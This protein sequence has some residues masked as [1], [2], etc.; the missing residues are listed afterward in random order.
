MDRRLCIL[1]IVLVF[2]TGLFCVT[3]IGQGPPDLTLLTRYPNP[4]AGTTCGV[5]GNPN[6]NAAKQASNRLKNRFKIPSLAQSISLTE[7]KRMP[8]EE[9]GE[10]PS[11]ESQSELD[12][13]SVIG[14]VVAVSL[15]GRSESCNCKASENWQRDAHIDLVLYPNEEMADTLRRD[16]VVVEVTERSRRLAKGGFLT[17]NIGTDWTTEILK[18]KL[19]GRWVRFT[20]YLFYDDDHHLESWNVDRD[21]NTGRDNWRATSWEVHP[22]MGIE[23]L[24]NR[25]DDILAHKPNFAPDRHFILSRAPVK[26]SVRRTRHQR[27]R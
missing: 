2:S 9:D 7:I 24:D 21:N 12:P 27:K 16:F 20:G 23:V 6:S 13:V 11:T 3:A 14:Y 1:L 5:E 8:F 4:T 25:P 26:R 22:V 15:G 17:S 19:K 10:L 18:A